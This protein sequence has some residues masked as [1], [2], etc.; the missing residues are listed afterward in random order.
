MT[1]ENLKCPYCNQKLLN[2][3]VP[4]FTTPCCNKLCA[5][6]ETQT[7]YVH[8]FI[9]VKAYMDQMGVTGDTT[10]IPGVT[11]RSEGN[12]ESRWTKVYMHGGW[13]VRIVGG[14]DLA[15]AGLPHGLS[16]GTKFS[17]VKDACD[18]ADF[19]DKILDMIVAGASRE[20]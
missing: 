18:H 2:Y 11:V 4:S 3:T 16:L 17:T 12:R 10:P 9:P 7:V 20:I 8:V 5:A 15:K 6:S 1:R 14:F 19:V 13:Y